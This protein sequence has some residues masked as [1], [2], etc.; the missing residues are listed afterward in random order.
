MKASKLITSML[1]PISANAGFNAFINGQKL[2]DSQPPIKSVILTIRNSM[3][4]ELM[5]IMSWGLLTQLLGLVF[6][7]TKYHFG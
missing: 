6:L 5:F 1:M 7:S 4:P 2:H 3:M